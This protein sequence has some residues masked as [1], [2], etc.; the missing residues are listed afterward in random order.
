LLS[1]GLFTLHSI[2]NPLLLL[3]HYTLL[4]NIL[5]LYSSPLQFLC[6]SPYY[7]IPHVVCSLLS[8]AYPW[9]L[10]LPHISSNFL[11]INYSCHSLV[12]P[13]YF[14]H[15]LMFYTIFLP[16]YLAILLFPFYHCPCFHF[17]CHSIF[18][19]IISALSSPVVSLYYPIPFAIPRISLSLF[20]LSSFPF[21]IPY[22]ILAFLS[23][24]HSSYLASLLS[25][26]SL[27]LAILSICYFLNVLFSIPCHSLPFPSRTGWMTVHAMPF[28]AI[29]ILDRVDD[30]LCDAIPSHSHL[31]QVG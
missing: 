9:F 30:C 28:L 12:I 8:W 31:G 17:I 25:C 13:C 16:L 27:Y 19:D 10:S 3:C 2:C 22:S 7:F 6:H 11:A 4:A 18:L 24:H 14:L 20:S 26:H 1:L 5:P 15:H 23:Y 21:A 29:P